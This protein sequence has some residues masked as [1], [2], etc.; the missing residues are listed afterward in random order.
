MTRKKRCLSFSVLLCL[1]SGVYILWHIIWNLLSRNMPADLDIS[2]LQELH[3]AKKLTLTGQNEPLHQYGY[4]IVNSYANRPGRHIPDTRHPSCHSNTSHMLKK[5]PSASIIITFH[6]VDQSVLLRNIASI[7]VRS[8]PAVIH[9]IIIVEDGTSP[10]GESQFLTQIPGIKVFRNKESQGR[11]VARTQAAARATGDVLVFVDGLTEVNVDWLSPLLLRLMESP[12]NLVAPVLDSIDHMTFE[13]APVS[14]LFRGGFDWSLQYHWEDI[15]ISYMARPHPMTPVRSP[16]ISGSV[17]AMR[18]DFFNWLGKYDQ[19]QGAKETEDIELSLRAWLCGGQV[20][21]VPCSK[22]GVIHFKKGQ[23]GV[24]QVSFSAYIRSARQV[25]EIWLDDYKRFFFAVRPSAR[26]QPKADITLQRKLKEKLKCRNFKWYLT[27]IYPQLQP[28][29]S[30]EVA[31]GHIQQGNSCI[32]FDPGQLPIVAKLRNCED[33]K[34]S[35]EWSWRKKGV[36]VSSGMCLTSDLMNTQGFVVV[37]F[38]NDMENQL[39]YRHDMKIVHQETN[40]C[41]DGRQANTGLLISD[42]IKDSASQ[43]WYISNEKLF[44]NPELAYLNFDNDNDHGDVH[45]DQL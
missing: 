24:P 38:C 14:T 15:P 8:R 11:G 10:D 12:R 13:Y 17:L 23:M 18:R 16:V 2:L 44:N 42:C 20:E 35:Q 19:T 21:I 4:H 22:V 29:I 9:E 41:L 45:D 37:Q 3:Y 43:M 33:D 28:L 36:I 27:F 6:Q 25:A 32:D 7:L 31:Y 30:D 26:M 5:L 34:D 40:L 1:F 39:W